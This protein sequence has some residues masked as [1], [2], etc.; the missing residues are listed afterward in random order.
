MRWFTLV[1]AA[2]AATLLALAAR[3][4]VA[5]GSGA[6]NAGRRSAN[7]IDT[8]FAFDRRGTLTVENGTEAIVVTGWDQDRVRVESRGGV[9]LRTQGSQLTVSSRPVLGGEERI[10]VSV[11][12][13]VRVIA[14]TGSGDITIRETRGDV[15]ADAIEGNVQL[16]EIGSAD[17]HTVNGE[18][19]ASGVVGNLRAQTVSGS[20]TII[21][22]RGDVDIGTVTGDLVVTAAVSRHV[23][24]KATTGDVTF[25]GSI[26]HTGVYEL[27]SHSGD[28]KLAL[29]HD[30]G[31]QVT[32]ST[33]SGSINSDFPITLRPGEVL[34]Q[35]GGKGKG[36]TTA[37]HFAF[38][39]GKGGGRITI[40]AFSG[41][42]T[43]SARDKP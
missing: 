29:P 10:E 13:G 38:Q 12:R 17:V 20:I 3:A 19:S 24:A 9:M 21:D 2:T 33:W 23:Q 42:I 39:I 30:A 41:D 27:A 28:V 11:P 25:G 43:I 1:R 16:K 37:R 18:V 15:A 5:Q 31:A 34:L 6:R 14:H 36:T 22:V 7:G 26:D 4:T 32:A 40:D 8:L 35:P